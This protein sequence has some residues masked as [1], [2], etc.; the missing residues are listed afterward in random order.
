[1]S[2]SSTLD[3]AKIALSAVYNDTSVAPTITLERLREL[4]DLL[5]EDISVLAEEIGEDE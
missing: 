1:M 2:T 5:N 3:A 4:R